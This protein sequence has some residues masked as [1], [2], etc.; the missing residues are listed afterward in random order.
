MRHQHT[1]RL[2]HCS[3]RH[4][5]YLRTAATWTGPW[6]LGV[7]RWGAWR[8]GAWRWCHQR[9]SGTARQEGER[10]NNTVSTTVLDTLLPLGQDLG[11]W[12]CG[13]G[14]LGG[15]G[16]GSGAGRQ[17]LSRQGGGGGEGTT[18]Q[19]MSIPDSITGEIQSCL[20]SASESAFV[21]TL[22]QMVLWQALPLQKPSRI[23]QSH[24][25]LHF[26]EFARVWQSLS[27]VFS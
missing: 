27:T 4:P 22:F 18:T 11:G 2:W 20:P 6:W 16:L 21:P 9:T 15:G 24:R 1:W 26:L 3:C 23:P 19:I 10:R 8:R 5:R 12:G 13:G 17:A 25:P 14:G 7:W